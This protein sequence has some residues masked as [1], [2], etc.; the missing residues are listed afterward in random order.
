MKVIGLII[1]L[2]LT[3]SVF[4][5]GE[6]QAQSMKRIDKIF[7][8]YMKQEESTESRQNHTEMELSLK[9]LQKKCDIRYFPK[10]IDVW[11]YYDP[12]D[13]PTRQLIK[14]ILLLDK[15]EGL[16][17]IDKRLKRKKKW[18]SEGN[19]PYSDLLSLR[20]EFKMQ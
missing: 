19:A 17:A 2:S 18:E 9:S 5:Q 16:K 14:P 1:L 15:E 10:L 13:F 12:T 11:M 7:D 6:D 8:N 4:G 3:F 20:N